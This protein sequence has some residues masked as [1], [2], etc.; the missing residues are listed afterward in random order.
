MRRGQ[1]AHQ[2]HQN[3]LRCG[4]AGPLFG[5]AA[6]SHLL[7]LRRCG[8]TTGWAMAGH[9]DHEPH[10]INGFA[11]HATN[12][13]ASH[14]SNGAASHA[15]Q[16]AVQRLGLPRDAAAHTPI[17]RAMVSPGMPPSQRHTPHTHCTAHLCLCATALARHL[18]LAAALRFLRRRLSCHLRGRQVAARFEGGLHSGR[19]LSCEL[20]KSELGLEGRGGQEVRDAE[21]G[22][23]GA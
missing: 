20:Q 10:A 15:M 13:F 14:A 1:R 11:S 23:R 2:P 9:G 7:D 16:L 3:E 5:T 22:M 12:G 19:E 18:L 17:P 8:G 4:E 21:D 6:A